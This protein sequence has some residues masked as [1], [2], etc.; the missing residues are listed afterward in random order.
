ML[1]INNEE[2]SFLLKQRDRV[3]E[4]DLEDANE[5]H[6]KKLK[7][8]RRIN[9]RSLFLYATNRRNIERMHNLVASKKYFEIKLRAFK[10]HK[11]SMSE[12]DL[13]D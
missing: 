3:I 2:A 10:K 7:K 13:N 9:W 8:I 4:M 1:K 5:T 11:N 12:L 6:L